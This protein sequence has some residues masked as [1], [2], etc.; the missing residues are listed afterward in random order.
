MQHFI[1]YAPPW[2]WRPSFCSPYVINL[3]PFI[4]VK[5]LVQKGRRKTLVTK[6]AEYQLDK[7]F[8]YRERM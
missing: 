7:E 5:P 3:S 1:Y 8:G 6:C 2:R 4:K